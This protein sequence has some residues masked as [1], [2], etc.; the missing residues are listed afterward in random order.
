MA[1][2]SPGSQPA[3]RSGAVDFDEVER[4]KLPLLYEAA[5]NFLDRGPRSPALAAQW[6]QFEEF[7]RSQAGWLNDYALYAVLRS[8]FQ[9]GA[10][11]E[12]PEPLRRREPQALAQAIAEHGRALAIEQALQ[13]AFSLQWNQLREAAARNGNPHPGRR[14]HLRQHGFGRRLGPSRN[15]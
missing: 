4:R 6:R 15:L 1:S 7:C 11:T 3:G 14:G 8:K 9:T 2:A 5:G 10:W 13:F 12:W